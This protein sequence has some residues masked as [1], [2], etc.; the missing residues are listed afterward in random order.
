[1]FSRIEFINIK[2]HRI[3]QLKLSEE[4]TK[5]VI[6]K[7]AKGLYNKRTGNFIDNLYEIKIHFQPVEFIPDLL[8]SSI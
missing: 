7:I 6:T 4:R 5:R 2:D 3:P 8:K 1:M